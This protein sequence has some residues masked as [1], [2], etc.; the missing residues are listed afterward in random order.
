MVD[1]VDI[2]WKRLANQP[3]AASS[4]G[5]GFDVSKL[6]VRV[7]FDV[8]AEWQPLSARRILE[9]PDDL[10]AEPTPVVLHLYQPVWSE[11]HVGVSE[12]APVTRRP[13][14][15]GQLHARVRY[16]A[17]LSGSIR[18]DC[19]WT[20]SLPIVVH[21]EFSLEMVGDWWLD[22][23]GGIAPAEWTGSAVFDATADGIDADPGAGKL[24]FDSTLP[25]AGTPINPIYAPSAAFISRALGG[26]GD[27]YAIAREPGLN[28]TLV[29][30]WGASSEVRFSVGPVVIDHADHVRLSLTFVSGTVDQTLADGEPL[31]V[32]LTHDGV[33][34]G[35]AS[36]RIEAAAALVIGASAPH[37]A[38]TYTFPRKMIAA[39]DDA[40][41][42]VP[43]FARRVRA[44]FLY[45]D[46]PDA[47]LGQWFFAFVSP[48]GET[49]GWIDAAS[50]REAL[51]GAGLW[52]PSNTAGV[53]FTNKAA[54]RV[55]V[56]PQFVLGL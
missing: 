47:P 2:V 46:P 42:E 15:A 25:E 51:F 27:I 43:A 48:R 39:L 52:L 28:M 44:H 13:P 35:D 3:Q 29:V 6:G 21:R 19:D 22:G 31:T 10:F 24:R 30:S 33:D 36:G 5:G 1:S 55:A 54:T 37:D 56:V 34:A 8:G 9:L 26:G 45:E 38:P 41:F 40:R 50:A 49:L 23:G 11:R 53:V 12:G 7:G 18:V 17:G 16:G 32:R 20:G 14:A 4:S